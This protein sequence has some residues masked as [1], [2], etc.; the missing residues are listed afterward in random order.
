MVGVRRVFGLTALLVALVSGLHVASSRA[1]PTAPLV[2][3][4]PSAQTIPPSGALPP[5]GTATLRL[6]AARGEREGAWIVARSGSELAASIERGS[7]GPV[8]VELAWGHFVRVGTT[9]VPDALLPWGGEARPF[10]QPNQPLYVRVVVPRGTAPGRYAGRV[11]VSVDGRPQAIP[12]SVRVYAATLPENPLPTSFHVSP[13]TY[14]S[15][16][17]RLHGLRSQAERRAAHAA[18]FG[19]LAEYG[20]SP[21]SWGFGEPR[22]RAGYQASSRWWL[23]SATNMRDAG[24]PGFPSMRIPISSN[25]TRAA[26]W[27]AG[28]DPGQPEAWCDYLGSVRSFWGEQGWLGRLPFLYA[29]DEPSLGGQ[30]LVARQSKVLHACWPGARTLMTGNPSPNGA[31]RFLSDGRDGDD[32]DIWAVLSRRYYGQ[33]TVPAQRRSRSRER[34][35]ATTIQGVRR[36]ASVWSYTYSAVQGTPGFAATEPLSN[37]RLF[38]LWNSLEGLQGILYGQGT[39]SYGGGDPLASLQR[40]GDF[41]LLYP[42]AS[43]PIPSARLEQIRDGIEDWALFDLV[44][45]KHGAREVRAILGDAGLFSAN[46]RGVK[47]A[48]TMGCALKSRTKFS[49]P[50]WSRDDSTADR[51]EAARAV[52]LGRAG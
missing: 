8:G 29:Q 30:R 1:T 43:R 16:V 35:L 26:N 33:F 9:S 48:C 18:L 25:R 37:P 20:V 39:T 34:E 50:L 31:N 6:R 23:D 32:V 24:A 40:D 52:A 3:A 27:V 38:L 36:V 22:S 49:W 44:R 19:L 28:L 14:L 7:L 41:V 12:V 13:A 46:R 51:I 15:T 17:A 4:F 45:R 10:E 2:T 42:G 21:S 47:L 11:V 5:G